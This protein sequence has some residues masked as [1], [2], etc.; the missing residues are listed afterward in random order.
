MAPVSLRRL[1]LCIGGLCLVFVFGGIVFAHLERDAELAEYKKNQF[2][3]RQMRAMYEFKHCE[4]D[5]FKDMEFCRQQESFHELLKDFFTRS[6]N[7]MEDEHK[8]TFFGSIFFVSTLVTTLGYGALH[9][10]THEGMVA[11]LVI[12]IIGIPMC[13]Y[14]LSLWGR[15]AV[16]CCVTDVHRYTKSPLVLFGSIFL[17]AMVGGGV[18]FM[19]LEG[20]SLIDGL[21]FSACTMMTIGFGDVMPSYVASKVVTMAFIALTLGFGASLVAVLSHNVEASGDKFVKWYGATSST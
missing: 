18:V 16:T 21:Y 9:P 6:G 4:E 3:Y 10:K 14:A 11:T 20:W 1:S 19:A 8:W 15:F 12:G 17:A 7:S 5:W 13:A 2:F